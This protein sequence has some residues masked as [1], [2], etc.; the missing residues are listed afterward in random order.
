MCG[1]GGVY[2]GGRGFGNFVGDVR[3]KIKSPRGR[4]GHI[5]N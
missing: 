4:G 2:S 5:F 1:G 3:V